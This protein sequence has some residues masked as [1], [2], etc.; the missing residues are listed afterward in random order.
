MCGLGDQPSSFLSKLL[1]IFLVL[2]PPIVRSEE[3]RQ[4]QVGPIRGPVHPRVAGTPPA[5][6]L[7]QQ[8]VNYS[9][10]A[11]TLKAQIAK[12][13]RQSLTR[14]RPAPGPVAGVGAAKPSGGKPNPT[15]MAMLKAGVQPRAQSP[16]SPE[17]PTDPYI[18]AEAAALNNDPNRIFA[19]VRDQ[20]GFEAYAGSLRGARGTLW[21]QAGNTLD[22]ASLLVS[23]LGAAGYTAQYEHAKITSGGTPNPATLI[24]G[25]FPA[26]PVLLGCTKQISNVSTQDP[27]TNGTLLNDTYDYYWVQYG[28][29][30]NNPTS[31]DPNQP[32]ATVG[33]SFATPDSNFTTVPESLRQQVTVKLNVES[34]SQASALF[35]LGVSSTTVLTQTFDTYSLV[36]NIL[37]VGNLVQ[38]SGAGGLD[39]SATTFTYTPYLLLGSGAANVSQDTVVTGTPYQEM[40]TNFPLGI[41]IVTGLFLEIDADKATPKCRLPC[42]RHPRRRSRITTLPLL[43]FSLAGSCAGADFRARTNRHGEPVRGSQESY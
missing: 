36:G 32:G 38:A 37:S 27:G 13:P 11:P 22:K 14:Q 33:Q 30:G 7:A 5:D 31:L 34:Y 20:V 9:R 16:A 43:R 39:I 29:A 26:A 24:D 25:M 18:V 41:T 28:T 12:A 6:S 1:A 4:V 15:E 8:Q 19:Y 2:Q 23:L 35:G 3:L 40:Y 21:A 17:D 10:T 42:R